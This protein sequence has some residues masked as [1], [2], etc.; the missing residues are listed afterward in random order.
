MFWVALWNQAGGEVLDTDLVLLHLKVSPLLLQPDGQ[1]PATTGLVQVTRLSERLFG[2]ALTILD[3]L[4][5]NNVT[6]S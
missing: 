6:S 4:S 5:H 3:F 1:V 2:V